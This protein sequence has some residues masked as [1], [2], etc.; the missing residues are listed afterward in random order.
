[1]THDLLSHMMRNLDVTRRLRLPEIA[2][3]CLHPGGL[4]CE[5]WIFP[6]R[7][8]KG[9]TRLRAVSRISR[10]R[11]TRFRRPSSFEFGGTNYLLR[12]LLRRGGSWLMR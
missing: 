5:P 11:W 8:D 12:A 7:S 2:Q 3:K 6:A 1:M 9:T 10:R 4:V